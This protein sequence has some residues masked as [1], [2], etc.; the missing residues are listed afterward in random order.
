VTS[1]NLRTEFLLQIWKQ[2]EDSAI[3]LA[4]NRPQRKDM[5]KNR[6]TE[7]EEKNLKERT[8]GTNNEQVGLQ[9]A[10][11]LQDSK[12]NCSANSNTFQK[13]IFLY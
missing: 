9:E 2:Q 13:G 1:T 6:L 10:P 8:A 5:I 4:S 3:L 11:H 7:T 12:Q